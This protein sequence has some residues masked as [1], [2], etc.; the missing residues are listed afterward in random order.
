MTDDA[1]GTTAL[2]A[3]VEDA[4]PIVGRWR[5]RYDPSAA[6]G[7]PAHVTVLVPFLT[8]ARLD[9]AA[10]AE[11]AAL[12]GEHRRFTVRF[13]RCA[14]F[15]DVLYLEPEPDQPFRELTEAL[16]HRWPETPPYGGAH[17]DVIPH[18]TVATGL[19]PSAL[20]AVTVD[21]EAALPLTAE[22]AA[23]DLFVNDGKRWHRRTRFP[24]GR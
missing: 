11:L 21:V 10:R 15:P 14:R 12:L 2:L 22:I 20:A 7:V 5:R 16:V 6:L 8:T 19:E 13:E 9:A 23:A 18:L 24:L 4:E 1:P 17:A 3:V